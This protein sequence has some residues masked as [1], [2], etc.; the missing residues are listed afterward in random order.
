MQVQT[1][2]CGLKL[3]GFRVKVQSTRE[4]GNR[5]SGA[6]VWPR[7]VFG[8]KAAKISVSEFSDPFFRLRALSRAKHIGNRVDSTLPGLLK[9]LILLPSVALAFGLGFKASRKHNSI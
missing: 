8:R 7:E 6:E 2:L 9:F 4:F 3:S 5:S 1:V